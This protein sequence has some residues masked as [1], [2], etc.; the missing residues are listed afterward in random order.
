MRLKAPFYGFAIGAI[1][2]LLPLVAFAALLPYLINADPVKKHFVEELRSWTGSE[3]TLAGPVAIE[4][5]FSLSLNAQ[6][7]E[8]ERFQDYPDLKSVKAGRIVARIAWTD[9]L[10]GNLDF[11]KVKIYDAKIRLRETDRDKAVNALLSLLKTPYKTPFEA[12]VLSNC[13]I[14]IGAPGEAEERLD[15]GSL[16]INL[17]QSDGRIKLSGRLAWLGEEVALNLVTRRLPASGG[18]QSRSVRLNLESRLLTVDFRGKATPSRSWSADGEVQM[19][20]P[21]ADELSHWLGG[22]FATGI[23]GPVSIAGALALSSEQIQLQSGTISAG[24]AEANGELALGIAP[25]AMR[26][27]GSLAFEQLGLSEFRSWGGVGASDARSGDTPLTTLLRNASIDL[28]V[29][30]R[31][32]VWDWLETGEAAFTLSGRSGVVSAEIARLDL[33]GGSLFGHVETSSSRRDARGRGAHHGGEY[34][35]GPAAGRPLAAG[36]AYGPGGRQYHGADGG[37]L[38]GRTG[39]KHDG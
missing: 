23:P 30:A 3:V 2:F 39:E 21:N 34:R 1:A 20:T 24:T 4:S 6:N 15:I 26:L 17:R 14:E 25:D 19:S 5:F 13:Q 8:F 28:R 9:L 11:D 16:V 12:L 29:S 32:I 27:E 37:P 35:R 18:D 22:G 36:V 38:D 33:F 31:R 10:L 7:V